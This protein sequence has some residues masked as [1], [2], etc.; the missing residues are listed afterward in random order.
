[1]KL[2][3]RED[4]TKATAGAGNLSTCP[5]EL[6]CYMESSSAKSIM[7]KGACAGAGADGALVITISS[8]GAILFVRG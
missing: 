6:T 8:G 1:M 5:G 2:L 4:K 3:R 7:E